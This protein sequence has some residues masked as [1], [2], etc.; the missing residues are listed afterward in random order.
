ML[1]PSPESAAEEKTQRY[2]VLDPPVAVA[3]IF[4]AIDSLVPFSYI[5]NIYPYINYWHAAT[6]AVKLLICCI[7]YKY[8]S[9]SRIAVLS[10]LVLTSIILISSVPSGSQFADYAKIFGFVTHVFITL[11]MIRRDNLPKYMLAS[12]G[13]MF[14]S[15][16]IYLVA[17]KTGHIDTTFG[18]YSYFHHT[19]PNL[20]SEI[21]AMS[22]VLAACVLGWVPFLIVTLPSLYAIYLMEG[23]AALVVALITIGAKLVYDEWRNKKRLALILGGL[24]GAGVLALLV[25]DKAGTLLNSAFLLHDK[26]RGIGSG[27]VGRDQLWNVAWHWFMASP[28]IGNGAGFFDRYGVEIHNFFLFGLSEFGILS[29]LI[30]GMIFYLFYELYRTNRKWFFCF[31]GIPVFWMFNDRFFNINPY[32]FLLYVVL[33]AH[34]NTAGMGL[35]SLLVPVKAR[36]PAGPAE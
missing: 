2:D 5:F 30:Y 6:L 29:L 7:Y 8:I 21:I 28:I 25:S 35:K 14:A 20:G 3:L 4:G 32:P 11:T 27:F 33:F 17:A 10:A 26:Y 19:H 34:A 31:L 9:I 24:A 12:V 13:V 16:L 18:R 1:A 36:P 23:R 15:T 22:I